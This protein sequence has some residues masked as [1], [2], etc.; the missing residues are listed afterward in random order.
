MREG[1]LLI[2]NSL[3]EREVRNLLKGV[4]EINHVRD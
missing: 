1:F 3:N 4:E 2:K